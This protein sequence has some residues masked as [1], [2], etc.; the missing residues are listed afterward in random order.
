MLG[1]KVLFSEISPVPPSF[2]NSASVCPC[3]HVFLQQGCI[4]PASHS[5]RRE[6]APACQYLNINPRWSTFTHVPISGPISEARQVGVMTAQALVW[7]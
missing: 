4:S 5:S 7:C 3:R 6:Q 2:F 1:I